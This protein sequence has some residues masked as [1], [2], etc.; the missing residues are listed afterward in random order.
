MID[1]MTNDYYKMNRLK[2]DARDE[3]D[4]HEYRIERIF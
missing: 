1:A 4:W 2:F 3:V